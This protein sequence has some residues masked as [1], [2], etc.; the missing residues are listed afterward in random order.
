MMKTDDIKIFARDLL[1]TI[2]P[3]YSE[4]VIYE[5]Y[6]AIEADPALFKRYQDLINVRDGNM[7]L[8]HQWLSRYLRVQSG[9]ISSSTTR[10]AP[11]SSLIN[12]YRVLTFIS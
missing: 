4:D 11:S 12:E 8:V 9:M 6:L 5:A 3:K 2:G 1:D 7:R 10:E